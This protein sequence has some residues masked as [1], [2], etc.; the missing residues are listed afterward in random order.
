MKSVSNVILTSMML[1]ATMLYSCDKE[2][3]TSPV[4]VDKSQKA[5]IKGYVYADL[6]QTTYGYELAPAGSKVIITM[7]YNQLLGLNSDGTLIDTVKLGNDGSFTYQIPADADGVNVSAKVIDFVY[8]QKQEFD[9]QHPTKPTVFESATIEFNG[10]KSNDLQ[11]QQLYL[12][13][14]TLGEIY[15]WHTITGTIYLNSDRSNI[16]NEKLAS[17]TQVVFNCDGWSKTVTVAADGKYTVQVPDGESIYMSYNF[18]VSGKLSDGTTVTF[19]YK[20]SKYDGTY[21]SDTNDEDLDLGNG[22]TE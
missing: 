6:D 16:G 18:T 17:G 20:D 3:E 2:I 1:L 8:D 5:T 7:S 19:R 14:H 21:Y 13:F 11:I 12:D 22:V 15:D 10:V 4:N 9:Q